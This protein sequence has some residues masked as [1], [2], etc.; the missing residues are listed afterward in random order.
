V[1]IQRSSAIS[2]VRDPTSSLRKIEFSWVLIVST[3]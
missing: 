1:S 3:L 2:R